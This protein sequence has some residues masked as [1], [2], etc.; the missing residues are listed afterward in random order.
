MPK[1]KNTLPVDVYGVM[2]NFKEILK[3]MISP[4]KF[5][6]PYSSNDFNFFFG[7]EREIELILNLINSS[8]LVL[9]YGMSS[10]GKT[11]LIQ[12][13]LSKHLNDQ[14]SKRIIIRRLSNINFSIKNTLDSNLSNTEAHY[15]NILHSTAD[16]FLHSGVPIYFFLDQFEELLELG[17]P[18]EIKLLIKNIKLLLHPYLPFKI[19]I[20]VREEYLGSLYSFEKEIPEFFESR[21]RIEPITESVAKRILTETARAMEDKFSFDGDKVIE[22]VV[23][24]ATDSYE[25]INLVRLQIILDQLY[26][27]AIERGNG[28]PIFTLSLLNSLGTSQSDFLQDFLHNQLDGLNQDLK[29]D[30]LGFL[31]LFLTENGTSRIVT[32]EEIINF[33]QESNVD[34]KTIEY[35]QTYFIANR[36]IR[37]FDADRLELAHGSLS[38][39]IYAM[40]PESILVRKNILRKLN[41]YL[42]DFKDTGEYITKRQLK[43]LE[44]YLPYLNLQNELA[45]FIQESMEKRNRWFG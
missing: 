28:K 2:I 13:G 42:E 16:I 38:E 40:L 3:T 14:N 33:S 10:V 15:D 8:K 6:D 32:K 11:S 9:I 31:E 25:K 12:G 27:S 7:R 44:P 37:T 20:T 17:S 26:K 29:I 1:T 41:F 23:K 43:Y 35:L 36:I 22:E 4:F 30:A 21:F 34:D 19:I 5:L 39:I 24:I 45:D 18:E